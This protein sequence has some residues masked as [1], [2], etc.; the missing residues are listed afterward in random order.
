MPSRVARQNFA[1]TTLD[2]VVEVSRAAL[3]DDFVPGLDL[4]C[5]QDVDEPLD[6]G[7]WNAGKEF[8]AQHAGQ[9][10]DT[11]RRSVL[12]NLDIARQ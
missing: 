9:P 8:R 5:F 2:H 1:T 6:V 7:G 3:F 12:R 11:A 4:H 10:I